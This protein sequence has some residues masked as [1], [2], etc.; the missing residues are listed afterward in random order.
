MKGK[1]TLV[2]Y[3]RLLDFSLLGLRL[4]NNDVRN[5]LGCFLEG[6]VKGIAIEGVDV[7]IVWIYLV[8]THPIICL[9]AINSTYNG[10]I[11][12]IAY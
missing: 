10:H 9:Y 12:P 3:T 6:E 8:P 7:S 1:I 2:A 4:G 11:I 5:G